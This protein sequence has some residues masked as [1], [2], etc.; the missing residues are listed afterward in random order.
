MVCVYSYVITHDTGFAPNPFGGFCTLATCKPLIRR[1]AKIGDWLVGTSSVRT[2]GKGKIIYA[3][4]IDE[5]LS[6]S[7]YGN[8]SRFS[9][10]RP[11]V[12]GNSRHG[13]CIYYQDIEGAWH[14]RRN[15]HHTKDHMERD[16]SGE[17]VLIS[18]LYWYFG[19]SAPELPESLQEII[20]SGPGH[21]R[22]RSQEVLNGLIAWLKS[23]PEGVTGVPSMPL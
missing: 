10:K 13:D 16:L 15:I 12:E 11:A 6:L 21:K 20:K 17:N 23:K 5:I 8:N 7:E 18:N 14:Q 2:L 1:T 9:V 3:A 22:T 4:R 19:T